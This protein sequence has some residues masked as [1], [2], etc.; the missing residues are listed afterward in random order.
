MLLTRL[1]VMIAKDY[2]AFISIFNNLNFEQAIAT[3]IQNVPIISKEDLEKRVLE[4]ATNSV[5]IYLY[6]LVLKLL[7]FTSKKYYRIIRD[8]KYKPERDEENG[9]T[10]CEQE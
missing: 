1:Y 2:N 5:V 10:V 4:N 8:I 6:C 9:E 3:L 7:S